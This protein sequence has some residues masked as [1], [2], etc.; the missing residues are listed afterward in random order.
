MLLRYKNVIIAF[1]AGVLTAMH[2][3]ACMNIN[4]TNVTTVPN[5]ENHQLNDQ[6]RSELALYAALQQKSLD[7]GSQIQKLQELQLYILALMQQT[8]Q[9]TQPQK[10]HRTKKFSDF[11]KSDSGTDTGFTSDTD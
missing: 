9:K 6:N 5:K 1:C 7:L 10:E 2:N 11:L 3:T 8:Y 4:S